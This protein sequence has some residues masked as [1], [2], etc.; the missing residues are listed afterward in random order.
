MTLSPASELLIPGLIKAY[1]QSEKEVA[2]SAPIEILR[3]WDFAVSKESVAMTLAH[4]Y[5]TNYLKS[6]V[7]LKVLNLQNWCDIGAWRPASE[8]LLLFK[9]A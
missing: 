2:L 5:G 8:R 7:G 6:G 3:N 4:Y 9:N 1:D